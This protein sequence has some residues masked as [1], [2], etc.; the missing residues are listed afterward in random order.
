MAKNAVKN[1]NSDR[2]I[3]IFA[4]AIAL[5]AMGVSI[6]SCQLVEKQTS[7]TQ[8]A[9]ERTQK[10]TLDATF[11]DAGNSIELIPVETNHRLQSGV[12]IFPSSVYAEPFEIREGGKVYGTGTLNLKI[13]KLTNPTAAALEGDIV[14]IGEIG[15]PVVILTYYTVSGDILQ[16]ASLYQLVVRYHAKPGDYVDEVDFVELL[17]AERMDRQFDLRGSIDIS[18]FRTAVDQQ[19]ARTLSSLQK[20]SAN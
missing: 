6:R 10:I 15:V 2:W 13:A 19:F 7:L 16:D 17:L 3:S 20:P 9:F 5:I 12:L 8:T 4:A 1:E 14:A 18:P 11:G